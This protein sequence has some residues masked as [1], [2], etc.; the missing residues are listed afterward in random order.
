MDTMIKITNNI[1]DSG[2]AI[3]SSGSLLANENNT[4]TI[5]EKLYSIS[6]SG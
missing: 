3:K 2:K 4:N 1:F 6:E 5:T